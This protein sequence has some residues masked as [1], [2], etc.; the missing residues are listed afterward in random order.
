MTEHLR[1]NGSLSDGYYCSNCGQPCGMMGHYRANTF[2]CIANPTLVTKLDEV[3]QGEVLPELPPHM[4]KLIDKLSIVITDVAQKDAELGRLV[5]QKMTS[6]NSVSVERCTV[7]DHEIK[8][9]YGDYWDG[10]DLS[11]WPY[12]PVDHDDC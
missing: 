10:Q 11:Q 9:I 6:G 4:F 7:Y 12:H 5:R 3:N 8:A 1:E 2:D